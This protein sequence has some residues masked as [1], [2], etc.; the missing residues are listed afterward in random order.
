MNKEKGSFNR[1]GDNDSEAFD[2]PNNIMALFLASKSESFK[3]SMRKGIE[4]VKSPCST[5]SISLVLTDPSLQF[6]YFLLGT[7]F[8]PLYSR[9]LINQLI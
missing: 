6:L 9:L 8:L 3:A 2:F 1:N 5:F 7:Q 4:S